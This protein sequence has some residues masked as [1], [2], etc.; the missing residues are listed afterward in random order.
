[1]IT[2]SSEAEGPSVSVWEL[3]EHG[4]ACRLACQPSARV[5]LCLSGVLVPRGDFR[6]TSD[7]VLLGYFLPLSLALVDDVPACVLPAGCGTW[8]AGCDV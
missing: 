1:M 2:S 8:L 7:V 4:V 3:A 6:R 5:A